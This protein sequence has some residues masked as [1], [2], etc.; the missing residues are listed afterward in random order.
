M[1]VKCS[2]EGWWDCFLYYDIGYV[3]FWEGGF[4]MR[5]KEWDGDVFLGSKMTKFQNNGVWEKMG[6]G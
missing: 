6:N 1:K 5:N 3:A 4:C 2:K